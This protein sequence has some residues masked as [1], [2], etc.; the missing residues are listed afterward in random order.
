MFMGILRPDAANVT[1]QTIEVNG[2][3]NNQSQPS[4]EVTHKTIASS[5]VMTHVVSV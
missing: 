5:I 1:F 3:G 4:P 2:G